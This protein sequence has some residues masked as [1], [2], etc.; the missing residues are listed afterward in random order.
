MKIIDILGSGKVTVSCELFPPKHGSELSGVK[1]V[2]RDT[3][4]L[5]PAFI[6]ITCGAGGG[7]GDRT[8]S[9]V[10]EAQNVCGVTALAHLTCISSGQDTVKSVLAELASLGI[11]NILALRGDMPEGESLSPLPHQR[12]YRHACDLM[13]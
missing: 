12:H 13:K 9:L 8:V 1:L 10:D 7:T 2:V 11:E 4:K 3:A 5:G 6:S